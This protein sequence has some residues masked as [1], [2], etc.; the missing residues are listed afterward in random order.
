MK[1]NKGI[2]TT[3]SS[4][5]EFI[6]QQRVNH[7]AKATNILEHIQQELQLLRDELMPS[8]EIFHFLVE[9]ANYNVKHKV[10]NFLKTTPL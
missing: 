3:V 4:L 7:N 8:M 1:S 5:A 2:I 6:L 9:K 10:S